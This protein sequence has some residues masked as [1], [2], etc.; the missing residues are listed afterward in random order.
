MGEISFMRNIPTI[1]I[2]T[3]STLS[4]KK[5]LKL[6]RTSVPHP[7]FSL[8]S[9]Y[10]TIQSF[11]LARKY[12]PETNAANGIG[13]AYRHALWTCLIMMYCSKVS[14]PEKAL[15]FCRKITDM[16]EEIFPNAPLE[17]TMDLHNNRVGMNLFMEMLAGIHRQFFETG[18]FVDKLFE[19]TRHAVILKDLHQDAGNELVYLLD[20]N[21]EMSNA[22]RQLL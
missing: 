7:V 21:E 19:K 6:L 2:R 16:H 3:I 8:L 11:T 5:I 20:E 1:F 13:N 10:A 9:L 17:K 12:F 18:F 22:E 14:S 4:F 15:R